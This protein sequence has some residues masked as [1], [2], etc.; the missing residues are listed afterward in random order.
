MN[1]KIFWTIIKEA[2]IIIKL[3]I[4]GVIIGLNI[5]A[6]KNGL[7]N[8]THVKLENP[9]T[10]LI[11]GWDTRPYPYAKFLEYAN[12]IP[13]SSI[14]QSLKSEECSTNKTKGKAMGNKF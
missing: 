13:A 1:V 5:L 3:I 9:S 6:T 10:G 4:F 12:E 2:K 8:I 7:I 14:I 11:P